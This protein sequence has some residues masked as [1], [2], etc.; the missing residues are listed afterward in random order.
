MDFISLCYIVFMNDYEIRILKGEEIPFQLTQIPEPPKSLYIRGS[1]PNK[2]S[3][4]VCIV[5]SRRHSSYGEQ[6][7]RELILGL[8]GY[9]ICIVSGLAIGIDG[10][11]HKSAIEAGL[12]TIAFPG[13][14]LDES[15]LYPDK[16]RDLAK[17]ILYSGG[18][19][20]SEYDN[21]MPAFEWTFPRRNRLMAGISESV[22]IIE[23][24]I[25]S[26]TLITSRLALDYNKNVGALPGEITS[27]LSIETNKLI[28]EGAI[29]ITCSEDILEMLG[30][31]S[32][33]SKPIQKE[34]LINLN[35]EERMIVEFL[36]IE[37]LSHESL[38]LKTGLKAQIVNETVSIL[39]INGIIKEI[40]GKFRLN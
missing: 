10:I 30:I 24:K 14:G 20:I 26:G 28:R 7:V 15:V 4:I 33:E 17:E 9:N 13:S 5:G 2:N 11:A 38:I 21:T 29:P 8:K 18:G 1:L 19:L 35:N 37:A 22:I 3:K 31:K 16:H 12:Q 39:E 34:L 6:A 32:S 25:K 40:G 36:Q 27:P 23:A